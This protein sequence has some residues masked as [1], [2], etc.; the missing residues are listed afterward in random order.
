MRCPRCGCDN[1]NSVRNC[2]VC[3]MPLSVSSGESKVYDQVGYTIA[4]NG[5]AYKNYMANKTGET[6]Q[7]KSYFSMASSLD[8]TSS[9]SKNYYTNNDPVQS[10]AGTYMAKPPVTPPAPHVY[11]PESS[12]SS[13]HS[14]ANSYIVGEYPTAPSYDNPSY[15]DPPYKNETYGKKKKPKRK[16]V[17]NISA[18]SICLALIAVS[19]YVLIFSG[20]AKAKKAVK[21]CFEAIQSCD[22][23]EVI[24]ATIPDKVIEELIDQLAYDDIDED[25]FIDEVNQAVEDELGINSVIISDV[26]IGGVEK[27]SLK[28][29]VDNAL[30]DSVKDAFDEILEDSPLEYDDEVFESIDDIYKYVERKLKKYDVD[31][32]GLYLVDVDYKLSIDCDDSENTYVA[33]LIPKFIDK[34]LVYRADGKYYVLPDVSFMLGAFT[35]PALE[36]Y[37]EKSNESTDISNADLIA[38]AITTA[39]SEEDVFNSV[40]VH[41]DYYGEAFFEFSDDGLAGMGSEFKDEVISDLGSSAD[42]MKQKMKGYKG[43]YFWVKICPYQNVIEV[44]RDEDL[45]ERIY[46]SYSYYDNYYDSDYYGD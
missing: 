40:S 43:D 46:P 2:M 11:K 42:S 31:V 12:V 5:E 22:A 21:D 30:D 19:L 1:S 38:M 41:T 24:N 17:T 7:Q 33:T 18:I 28:E 15:V 9:G 32:N 45:T 10:N 25:E 8:G 29:Y 14:N 27:V 20:R 3:G 4:G 34:F 23:E 6:A 36:T 26:R 13:P 37:V 39:W 35:V 44:Y 16:K